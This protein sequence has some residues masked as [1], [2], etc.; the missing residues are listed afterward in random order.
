[1]GTLVLPLLAAWLSAHSGE[2]T[3]CSARA[4][5]SQTPALSPSLSCP[6]CSYDVVRLVRERHPSL[7]LPVIL[8]S[9]NSR[10]EHVVEGLQV[11]AASTPLLLIP[12]SFSNASCLL[13]EALRIP[14]VVPLVC[15]QQAREACGSTAGSS[16]ASSREEH[17]AAGACSMPG[18]VTLTPCP[19]A[20]LRAGRRQ[21]LRQQA[22]WPEGAGGSHPGAA[23]YAQL[24]TGSG[25]HHRLRCGARQHG[26]G[27][28]QVR[29]RR[30]GPRHRVR[31]RRQ[32][33]SACRVGAARRRQTGGG[34]AAAAGRWRHSQRCWPPRHPCMA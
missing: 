18:V 27:G 22:L 24:C 6:L 9:A 12:D 16:H 17:V 2:A 31:R 11:G 29:Q 10:E 34:G 3:Q 25:A 4:P 20:V 14:F 28:W 21:R 30:R 19:V 26:G 8:V 5:L 13:P 23:S 32:Q 33:H 7:M 15:A 1:M